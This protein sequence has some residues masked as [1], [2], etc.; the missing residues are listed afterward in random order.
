MAYLDDWIIT[1]LHKVNTY[2]RCQDLLP[3]IAQ[4]MP[5]KMQCIMVVFVLNIV[6][7]SPYC[8]TFHLYSYYL[9]LI[10]FI[11]LFDDRCVTMMYW[12][13]NS[14]Y[15]LSIYCVYIVNCILYFF[16]FKLCYLYL[17]CMLYAEQ[18]VFHIF[19]VLYLLYICY[20]FF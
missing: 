1:F 19:R 18:F 15:L 10:T 20:V 14:Y 7:C 4:F 6:N 9:L 2:S 13:L 5:I 16:T 3:Y 8:F 12:Y 11:F 17:F